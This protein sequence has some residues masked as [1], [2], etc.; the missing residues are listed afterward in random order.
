MGSKKKKKPILTE[1]MRTGPKG[2]KVRLDARTVIT[3]STMRSFEDWQ[4]KYPK[5]EIID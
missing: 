1:P 5:A 3:V 2:F 4:K